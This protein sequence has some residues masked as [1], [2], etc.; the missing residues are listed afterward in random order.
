V[1]TLRSR[2]ATMAYAGEQA[3][4]DPNVTIYKFADTI[5]GGG[6]L[7]AW[8][9]TSSANVVSAYSLALPSATK[10]AKSVTLTDKQQNGVEAPLT[11]SGGNVT[12]DISETPTIVLVDAL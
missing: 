11:I 1:A 8:S 4:G 2:L 6:A 7:V 12:L 10:T 3:S 9:P 5:S